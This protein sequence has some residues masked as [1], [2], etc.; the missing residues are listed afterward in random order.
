MLKKLPKKTQ[1]EFIWNG[2][3]DAI[4]EVQAP[5][6][7]V[8]I[9]NK[10]KSILIPDSENLYIEGNNTDA[11]K[12]LKKDYKEKIQVVYIDP[13]YNT[14][15]DFIYKDNYHRTNWCS[16]IYKSLLLSKDLISND[17]V[18]FISIDDNEVNNLKL[19]CDEI[20]GE[21]NFITKFIYEKTQHYGRQ[22]LNAYSNAEYI[23]CYAKRLYEN[24]LKELLV[25]RVNAELEDAPLY[26]ASNNTTILKFPPHT[27]KFKIPDGTY[28]STDSN[29]YELLNPVDVKNGFNA[30]NF[31][32]KFKSR[33][34]QKKVETEI[35]MG[36]YFLV[37]TKNFAIRAE[38]SDTKFTKISPKQIIFTNK[39]NQYCTY[40]RF[41]EQ[42]TTS[43]TG[44]KD[45]EEILEDTS[46]SYPKPVS[47]IKYLLSLIYDYKKEQFVKDY[48]VLDF[49]SGSG[50]TAQAVL[51]LN[52][53]DNG[54]RK[55]I[56][57]QR[58]E[59]ISKQ[60]SKY[61]TICDMGEERIRR[62]I[63]K[64][65]SNVGFKVLKMTD[66]Q[67]EYTVNTHTH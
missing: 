54:N 45:I 23:L 30:N 15:K 17:G 16:M 4:N 7:K 6:N 8:F 39:K 66:K 63:K 36:T 19:I 41:G 5:S 10:E 46:F 38:Y 21:E 52:Q 62:C 1:Y 55:F 51:E 9:L 11:L 58:P 14:K 33:W 18:I 67:S 59:T 60:E 35:K 61:K 47:L 12:I 42:V 22:K 49:F 28:S 34:S 13:P 65:K 44:K 20:F 25:E 2:K 40:S 64:L 26:N 56:L 27:V 48:T 31:S 50:T 24:K 43:E 53:K 37:K 3:E 29:I 32:I 57:I